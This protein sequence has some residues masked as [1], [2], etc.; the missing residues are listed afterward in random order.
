MQFTTT[1][2]FMYVKALPGG[3]SA[4]NRDILEKINLFNPLL[5]YCE[6]ADLGNRITSSGY[7]LLYDPKL[8]VEHYWKGW[9]SLSSL[10]K[11]MFKYGHGRAIAI[12]INPKLFSPIRFSPLFLIILLLLI[13]LLINL[14]LM[15]L[16]LTI[17]T[18]LY[19]SVST[20]I[21]ILIMLRL[22]LFDMRGVLVLPLIHFPYSVGLVMGIISALFHVIRQ[23]LSLQAETS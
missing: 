3:N 23:K 21:S 13:R 16:V 18:L 22:N 12:T 9:K 6:D 11:T 8:K 4:Y 17:I 1:Q 14:R 7:K 10:A 5:R 19:L 15:I 20:I 2:K